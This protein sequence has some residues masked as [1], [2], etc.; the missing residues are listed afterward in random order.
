LVHDCPGVHAFPQA[1]QLLLSLD[2]FTQNAPQAV[3]PGGH[4]VLWHWPLKQ[5]ALAPHARPHAP[6]LLLSNDV[7]TQALPPSAAGQL[8]RP[9]KQAHA[10]LEQVVPGEHVLPHEPQLKLSLDVFTH[11]GNGKLSTVQAV[12]PSGHDEAEQVPEEH[13]CPEPHATPHPPQLLG[14]FDVFTQVVAPPSGVHAVKPAGHVH[15]GSFVSA[16][17]VFDDLFPEHDARVIA[18]MTATIANS[19][20]RQ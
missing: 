4:T 8:V 9:A 14:S 6:Q 11:T 19:G 13:V 18:L 16:D 20:E 2:V 1:P 3:V 12:R 5:F 7:F 17:C 15:G 10:P